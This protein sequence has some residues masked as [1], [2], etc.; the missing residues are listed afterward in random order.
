MTTSTSLLPADIN[1]TSLLVFRAHGSVFG[2]DSSTIHQIHFPGTGPQLEGEPTPFAR[3][4]LGDD[5]DGPAEGNVTLLEMSTEGR[6]AVIAVRGAVEIRE[7]DRQQLQPLPQLV[8]ETA[9]CAYLDGL[10]SMDGGL[11][12]LVDLQRWVQAHGDGDDQ[13]RSGEGPAAHDEEDR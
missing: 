5:D 4:L 13:L 11:V 10:V 3:I 1:S 6:H 7:L 12:L 8:G 2:I 9:S